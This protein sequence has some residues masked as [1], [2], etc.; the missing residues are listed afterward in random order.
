MAPAPRRRFQLGLGMDAVRAGLLLLVVFV[1][2]VG[3][4][5]V[6]TPILR[7]FGYRRVLLVNGVLAAA[8]IGACALI[9][10]GTPAAL[11]VVILLDAGMTRSMQFTSLGTIAFADV[12]ERQMGDANALSNVVSQVSM[13]AGITLGAM[14]VQLGQVLAHWTSSSAPVMPYRVALALAALVAL[15]GLAD[16]LRL[17]E[18]AGDRFLDRGRGAG[19]GA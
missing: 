12:P 11:V 19:G 10:P 5:L 15:A 17:P 14:S 4:K 3:M 18:G 2:N 16:T 8:S 13:A 7:R 6:T 9:G 1:G